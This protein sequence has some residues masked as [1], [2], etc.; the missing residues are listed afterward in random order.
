MDTSEIEALSSLHPHKTL[1]VLSQGQGTTI[2]LWRPDASEVHLEVKGKIVQ[3][4]PTHL[5]G[6][7]EWVDP[8]PLSPRNYRIYHT[9]GLLAH[10]PYAFPCSIGELDFHLMEKGCH[11][12]LYDVLGANLCEVEGVEG[13]RF[14]LWAPNAKKV[15]L[16]GDFNGWDGRVNPMRACEGSGVWEI[17]IPQLPL[18]ERYKFEVTSCFG[19]VSLKADPMA[20]GAEFRPANASVVQDPH[21][22]HWIDEVWMEERKEKK[23]SGPMVIYE[24]HLGSWMT[25]G[26]EFHSYRELAVRL[27]AYCQEMGFTHVELLPVMEHPLDESWGYQVTGFFSV[28]SRFGTP[29]DFQFFVQYLHQHGIGVIL[30]WVPGHFPT[31]DYALSRFDGTALYEHAD[32]RQGWHPHWNTHIFNYG[33]KEVSNFLIANALY[34]L[35]VMH[36]DGLRVDAVA[37]ML[38]LDYGREGGEWIPNQYGGNINLE[39]VEFLKHLNSAVQ[40]RVPG[41]WMIAEESTAFPGV[42]RPV[43]DGGLGFDLKWNM[44]WMHDTLSYFKTDPVYRKHQHNHLTFGLLYAFTEKFILPFSH[45][46]V[47]HG[48]SSLLGKMPGDMWQQFANLRLLYSYH[49]CQPGKKLMFMGAELGQWTEWSC[50]GELDW[51]LLDYPT[52][53]GIQECFKACNRSY[54]SHEALWG[55][56]F[57][58]KGFQWVSHEDRDHS[59]IAYWRKSG[60]KSVLCIHNFTPQTHESY[61][62]PVEGELA[63]ILNTDDEAF[64]GSGCGGTCSQRVESGAFFSLPPL[65]TLIFSKL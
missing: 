21:A 26:W 24:L 64:G 16:V 57:D 23:D 46:E 4:S 47:V 51:N 38:Y 31:D 27:T 30:D 58:P 12:E 63:L 15:A 49:I 14:A 55:E 60:E 13:V 17:F 37:S 29:E 53:E 19:Q 36:V 35:E 3:A 32:R 45:D 44:G 43:K 20:K 7:F 25:Q 11:Y 8:T 40:E 52:H 54:T 9:S 6:M 61:W 39:A 22:F 10:D 34:W 65:A 62:F 5:P 2:R 18:E 41:V 28:T 42:T 33:R 59:I 1:G 48:K 50:K 56:D